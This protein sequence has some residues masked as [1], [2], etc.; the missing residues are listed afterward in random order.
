MQDLARKGKSSDEVT[1]FLEIPTEDTASVD[2]SVYHFGK[3]AATYFASNVTPQYSKRPLKQALLDLP[4]P[5][6]QLVI[7]MFNFEKIKIFNR[8]LWLY[9]ETKKMYNVN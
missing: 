7:I 8:S 5:S 1:S 9:D 3:F 6:D 2:F 4:L